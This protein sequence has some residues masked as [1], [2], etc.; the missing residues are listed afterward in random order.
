LE[1]LG[2]GGNTKQLLA[3]S[4][5]LIAPAMVTGAAVQIFLPLVLVSD[6]A[7]LLFFRKLWRN[8][9]NGSDVPLQP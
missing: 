5:G 4:I 6:A 7:A 1:T 3:Y 2:R 9:G 8:L